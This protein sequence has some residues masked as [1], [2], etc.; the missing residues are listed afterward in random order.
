MISG[1]IWPLLA[2]IKRELFVSSNKVDQFIH[3][4]EELEDR[5]DDQEEEITVLKLKAAR[6]E[7]SL[8]RINESNLTFSG[9]LKA[10]ILTQNSLEQSTRT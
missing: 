10:L 1:T 4:I 3:K 9:R 6:H 5:I 7:E 8:E 2:E